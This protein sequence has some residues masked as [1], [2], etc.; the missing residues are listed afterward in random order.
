MIKVGANLNRIEHEAANINGFWPTKMTA[1]QY[2]LLHVPKVNILECH[3]VFEGKG[4][5]DIVC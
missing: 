3:L 2:V 1:G 4:I 5:L